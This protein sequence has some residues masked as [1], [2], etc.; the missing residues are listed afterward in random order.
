MAELYW[1]RGFLA[2]DLCWASSSRVELRVVVVVSACNQHQHP[3]P[4]SL[5][6]QTR[7]RRQPCPTPWLRH[8]IV[9]R[10]SSVPAAQ[11]GSI[12]KKSCMTRR[13]AKTAL[14]WGAQLSTSRSLELVRPNSSPCHLYKTTTH[15]PSFRFLSFLF[16]A[17][18]SPHLPCAKSHLLHSLHK[19]ASPV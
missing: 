8:P 4:E 9:P 14:P 3:S 2:G 19:Q 18:S 11:H 6:H 12:Q 16:T 5:C 7:T 17:L 1:L 13:R 10:P 15:P